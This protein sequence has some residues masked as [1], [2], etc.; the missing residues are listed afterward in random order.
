MDRRRAIRW[1]CSEVSGND[2]GT[3]TN[4]QGTMA[5]DKDQE[6]ATPLGIV[7]CSFSV[8][9]PWS[10]GL[11]H[12]SFSSGRLWTGPQSPG[13]RGARIAARRRR[14]PRP[15]LRPAG[16]LIDCEKTG[17][18]SEPWCR[19]LREIS[20]LRG[21]CP[22]FF[23]GRH[24]RS[25]DRLAGANLGQ[26]RRPSA[27]CGEHLHG[28]QGRQEMVRLQLS[29]RAPRARPRLPAGNS[30][31]PCEPGGTSRPPCPAIPPGHGPASGRTSP[32]RTP[33]ELSTR[34]RRSFRSPGDRPSR[35]RGSNST[36]LPCRARL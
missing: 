33:R 34:D 21:A 25:L 16:P 13:P 24:V 17:T 12:W 9:A 35:G 8:L 1:I 30:P 23:T 11:G 32:R 20:I 10:L 15:R 29:R 26:L 19:K 7:P 3:M 5:N 31:R 2:Q 36:G 18:G 28:P 14:C 6:V 4:D 22:R 27:Q